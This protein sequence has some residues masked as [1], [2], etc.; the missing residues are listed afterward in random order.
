MAFNWVFR[1]SF[2][3]Q[4]TDDDVLKWTAVLCVCEYEA[5]CIMGN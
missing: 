3:K 1:V 4:M 2:F 5:D